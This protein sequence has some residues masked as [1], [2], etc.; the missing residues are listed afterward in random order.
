MLGD[1]ARQSF[2]L[3]GYQRSPYQRWADEQG[4]PVVEGLSVYD[5]NAVE[6]A[7]WSL[8]GGNAAFIH[9]TGAEFTNNGYVGEI[10]PGGALKPTRHLYEE[11][12]FVLHGNGATSVWLD[13]GRKREFE[14]QVGSLFAVPLNATYQMFNTS[15]S[16]PARY[17]AVTTAPLM[18]DLL[19]NRQFIF[20]NDF[21]F[22]D[23]FPPDD[24]DY[25]SPG[26]AAH[27]GRVW[28][29]NF[30]PDVRSFQLQDWSERGGR[31]RNA[32]FEIADSTMCASVS[33]FEVGMYKKAHRHGPGAH[34]VVLSGQGYSL[35]WRDNESP[36]RVDWR[37]GSVFAPPDM[38]FHQHFNTGPEPA[39]YM[40]LRWGSTKYHLFNYL[41]ITKD[42]K[43][44]GDQ[45]EY[46]DED[47]QIR[48]TFEAELARNGVVSRMSVI[49]RRG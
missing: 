15:G 1:D 43:E 49:A 21:V 37:A 46:E 12:V 17:Y 4:I 39:R 25:F 2:M 7:P 33:E 38:W 30:V 24:D 42:V 16:E 44:G 34:I 5:L 13:P 27:P 23:R 20:D 36:R 10:P 45:I 8:T 28:E 19:H 31:G 26:G 22:D 48:G 18:M 11:F 40:P 35:L 41:G 3:D 32:F 14:W 6:L 9:L 29:T 47:P